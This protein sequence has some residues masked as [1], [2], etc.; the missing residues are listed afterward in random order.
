[1]VESGAY[2]IQIGA[3]SRDIRQS[4]TVDVASSDIITPSATTA[5]MQAYWQ[6]SA[7]GF[8]ATAFSALWG[9]PVPS[10]VLRRGSF[11]TNTPIADMHE[12]FLGRLVHAQ[13]R[14][15]LKRVASSD[16]DGPTN[17]LFEA[18]AEEAPLRILLM[19]GG[20]KISNTTLEAIV[21]WVNGHYLRA[22][23][24]LVG[25]RLR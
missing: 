11:T 1:V 9:G 23:R 18:M 12:S 25:N 14:A 3:S 5:P 13:L 19:S 20:G 7:A 21:A 4:V 22:I 8:S 2:D 10:S 6:P 15:G 16:T 24:I 17:K